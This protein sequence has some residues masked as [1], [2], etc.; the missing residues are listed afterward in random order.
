MYNK[1]MFKTIFLFLSFFTFSS[2]SFLTN[3]PELRRQ[4]QDYLRIFDKTET[5]YGFE[6]FVENLNTVE[7]YNK[8]NNDGCKMYLTQYSDTFDQ[9]AVL[10]RCH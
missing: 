4:Y 6:T 7:Y 10:F 1:K 5:S 9:E 2:Y 3:M 8:N